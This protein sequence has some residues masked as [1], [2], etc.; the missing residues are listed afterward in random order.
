M[1]SSRMRPSEALDVGLKDKRSWTTRLVLLFGILA[2]LGIASANPILTV[3]GWALVPV[4]FSLL[5]RPGEIPVL[6]F[7]AAFQW[8]QVFAPILKANG[9]GDALGAATGNPGLERA[10]WLGLLA[11]GVFALG[12]RLGA[13]RRRPSWSPNL[14][15]SS[16][17]LS[18]RRLAIG[19]VFSFIVDRAAEQAS[20]IIPAL[21][22]LVMIVSLRW[23]VVFLIF[24]AA[25][26]DRR[27]RALAVLVLAMELVGGFLGYFS[28]FKS[29]LF[30]AFV[31][32]AG[33]GS[34][35]RRVLRPA[36][37]MTLA[38][39]VV[40]VGFWQSIK[41]DYRDFLSQGEQA[42]I[43]VVSV[44]SRM[45]FL[46][47]RVSRFSIDDLKVGVNSG[48]ERLGYL[49]YFGRAIAFV[50]SRIPYQNGRLWAEALLH[51]VTPRMLFPNKSVVNDSDRT[52]EFTGLRVATAEEGASIS[53]GYVAESY[54]D[55]GPIGMFVPI[56]LL[57]G[58]WGWAFRW[59]NL[60]SK[61]RLLGVAVATNLILRYAIQFEASNVK[62]FGG[63]VAFLGVS[64]FLLHVFDRS[65]WR[66]FTGGRSAPA[67]NAIN[68]PSI[69]PPRTS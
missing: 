49:E 5:W 68:A 57:G 63:G 33:S 48:F 23:I 28:S 10:G 3:A 6:L 16:A 65:I 45:N 19:Y 25:T 31:I 12:M 13:G 46:V 36:L 14:S 42:Q 47:D 34:T 26:R 55:F 54:I 27:F 39:S 21:R 35:I 38:V 17:A 30:L 40:L 53:I 18:P 59:L 43:V 9:E 15:A 69:R 37:I 22:Q 52:N 11:I 62:L 61:Y 4:L 58:F 66:F 29:I 24:W 60:A 50:P 2:G 44:Q 67:A 41:V 1:I 32:I 8:L 7:A 64:W 51:V 56:A 20:A